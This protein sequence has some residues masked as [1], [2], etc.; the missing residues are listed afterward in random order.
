VYSEQAP[1][2][3]IPGLWICSCSKSWTPFGFSE[4]VAPPLAKRF[5]HLKPSNLVYRNEIACT[6][7]DWMEF[8][9]GVVITDSNQSLTG[10]RCAPSQFFVDVDPATPAH[11][12]LKVRTVP[13][14]ASACALPRKA[15]PGRAVVI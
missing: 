4:K 10:N 6:A 13:H 7:T 15:T 9:L 3:A 5:D 14:D 1:L 11:K 2:I 8:C 12:L